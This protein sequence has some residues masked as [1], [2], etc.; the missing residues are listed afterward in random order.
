MGLE[1]EQHF[2]SALMQLQIS[3]GEPKTNTHGNENHKSGQREKALNSRRP[4]KTLRNRA[5]R[6]QRSKWCFRIAGRLFFFS[7]SLG[8]GKDFQIPEMWLAQ[9]K[10]I[11]TLPDL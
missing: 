10:P 5:V 2:K 1:H 3:G 8:Y 9:Y 6:T 11:F 4:I 7:V